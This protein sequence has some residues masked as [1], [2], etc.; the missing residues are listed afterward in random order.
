MPRSRFS[1]SAALRENRN[2]AN[3]VRPV[4]AVP[5]CCVSLAERKRGVPSFLSASII[6][7]IVII[8]TTTA[9]LPHHKGV[10]S[11][12]SEAGQGF[13]PQPTEEDVLAHV[14]GVT[15]LLKWAKM[16]Y[17][18]LHCTALHC[19]ALHRTVLR[20]YGW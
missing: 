16:L 1:L 20:V 9:P 12:I 14:T 8:A 6:I 13:N 18:A 19:T 10:A 11:I 17:V 2:A 7:I 4:P 15:N 5:A 3:D